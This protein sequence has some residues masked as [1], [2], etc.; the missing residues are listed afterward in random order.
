MLVQPSA[1]N[2]ANAGQAGLVQYPA[3]RAAQVGQIP[4][5]EPDAGERVAPGGKTMVV[6]VQQLAGWSELWIF[7][8]SPAGV[9]TT[10][11][12]PPSTEEPDLGY[13]ELAGF[14]PDG[15]TL[16]L[17]KVARAGGRVRRDFEVRSAAT[18]AL[19]KRARDPEKL[20]AFKRWS[21]PDWRA[22][23]LALR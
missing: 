18:L 2:D 5:V 12:L 17:A 7:R 15:A 11:T 4:A 23:T 6:V 1:R 19:Q 9:W 8:R 21:A 10:D 14:S 3:H 20:L 22:T 13:V 16:L